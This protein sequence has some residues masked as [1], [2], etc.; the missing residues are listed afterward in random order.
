MPVEGGGALESRYLQ[1]KIGMSLFLH[2]Y[3]SSFIK[4]TANSFLTDG[5]I[6]MLVRFE[7]Y[8]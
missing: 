3:L 1:P 7:P 2:L 5:A 6:T 4:F 8:S